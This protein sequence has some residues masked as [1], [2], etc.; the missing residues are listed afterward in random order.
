MK[1]YHNH[2]AYKCPYCIA[3]FKKLRSLK[4]HLKD[5]HPEKR[6]AICDTGKNEIVGAP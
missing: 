2:K 3:D 6:T 4:S 1:T 5:A